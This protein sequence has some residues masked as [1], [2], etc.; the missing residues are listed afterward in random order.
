MY[1][2]HI[3]YNINKDVA[4]DNNR[5]LFKK[6]TKN[7]KYETLFVIADFFNLMS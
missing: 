6:T 2:R 1:I 3:Y 4:Y 5:H 7:H